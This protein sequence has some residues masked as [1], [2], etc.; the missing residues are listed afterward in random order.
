MYMYVQYVCICLS[1][2]AAA[3]GHRRHRVAFTVFN[4]ENTGNNPQ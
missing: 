4:E 3:G 1:P 2:Y